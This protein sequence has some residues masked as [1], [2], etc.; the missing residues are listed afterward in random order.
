M[1]A[2]GHRHRYMCRNIGISERIFEFVVMPRTYVGMYCV[3]I[4]GV[5]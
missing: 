2:E 4:F 3:G 1:V 5:T